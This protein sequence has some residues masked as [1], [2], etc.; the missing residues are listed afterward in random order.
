MA[1]LAGGMQLVAPKVEGINFYKER[2]V[3][4]AVSA[5]L[6]LLEE[7]LLLHWLLISEGQR[8]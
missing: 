3:S 4:Q 6:K 7:Y 2:D 8:N 1:T 5:Y